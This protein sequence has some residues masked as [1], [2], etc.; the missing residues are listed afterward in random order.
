M[1]KYWITQTELRIKKVIKKKGNKLYVNWKGY[2]N[3]FNSW[4]DKKKRH[5]YI[6]G[7]YYTERTKSKKVKVELDLSNY[8]AKYGVKKATGGNTSDFAKK[9]DLAGLKS[10]VDELGVDK[11]RIVPVDLSKRLTD[12]DKKNLEKK[13]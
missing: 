10:Y 7:S 1:K 2:S 5:Y 9:W 13:D 3:S 11:L 12:T 8:A 4:A 6:K